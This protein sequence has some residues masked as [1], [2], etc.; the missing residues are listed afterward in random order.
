MTQDE[1]REEIERELFLKASDERSYA[2]LRIEIR[3]RE[4][5]IKELFDQ[6]E[7]VIVNE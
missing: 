7:S 2:E 4:K 6:Y 3:N 1:L 5:K